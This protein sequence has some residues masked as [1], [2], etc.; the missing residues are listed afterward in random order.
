M[1]PGIGERSS[2]VTERTSTAKFCS[3]CGAKFLPNAS[4]CHNCGW[5]VQGIPPRAELRPA[6][7]RWVLPVA[8]IVALI[9]LIVF[10]SGSDDGAAMTSSEADQ[11]QPAAG[12]PPDISSMSPEERADRL[13]NRVM[14]L[15][16]DGKKDSAAFFAPMAISALESLAPMNAHLRYDIGLVALAGGDVDKAAALS[17]TILRERPTHLLGLVLA[18]R[19]ADARGDSAAGSA[20]RKKLIAAES[21]ERAK[22]LPEYGDH[23]ADLRAAL[24]AARKR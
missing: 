18:S 22:P 17:D 19:V 16:S 15:W 2:A 20:I 9:L 10:R 3:N 24:D 5:S 8:A 21:S 12:V 1:D 23:D 11:V 6:P 4:F 13:F 7:L 14:S